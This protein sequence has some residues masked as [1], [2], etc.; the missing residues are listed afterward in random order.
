MVKDEQSKIS[1]ISEGAF[2]HCSCLLSSFRGTQEIEQNPLPLDKRSRTDSILGCTR[3][4]LTC[5]LLR[6]L[7]RPNQRPGHTLIRNPAQG[8]C[9][10]LV[11][12]QGTP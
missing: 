9:P 6:A 7:P 11:N 10:A 1:S 12:D 4:V 2:L 3:L 5:L 8:Y